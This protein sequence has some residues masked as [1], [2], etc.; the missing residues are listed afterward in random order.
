MPRLTNSTEGINKRNLRK[1]NN[2]SMV[3]DKINKN[4]KLH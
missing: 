2:M 4:N 3:S 1:R